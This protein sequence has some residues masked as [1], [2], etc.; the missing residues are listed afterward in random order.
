MAPALFRKVRDFLQHL[1]KDIIFPINF[2]PV[3][4]CKLSIRNYKSEVFFKKGLRRDLWIC[5][6]AINGM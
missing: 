1:V 3:V 2:S 6:A 5:R 4:R